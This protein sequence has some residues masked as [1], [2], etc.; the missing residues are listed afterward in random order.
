[1]SQKSTELKNQPLL[2]IVQPSMAE[3]RVDVQ[4]VFIVKR[5]PR[6]EEPVK[7]QAAI[8]E[9]EA[10]ANQEESQ[11]GLE[12]ALTEEDLITEEAEETMETEEIEAIAEDGEEEIEQE[13]VSKR[14]NS[15][16]NKSFKDMTLEE[17]VAF[18]VNRPHY[19]PRAKCKVQTGQ[20]TYIGYILSYEEGYVIMRSMTKI[21][22]FKVQ[23]EDIKSIQIIGL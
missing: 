17:K 2:Y 14:S 8:E 6:R 1:M 12:A 18:L 13:E 10:E 11:E 23:F 21:R 4:D 16:S 22:E 19:I 3:P 15:W 9:Q 5:K 20:D 7:Q